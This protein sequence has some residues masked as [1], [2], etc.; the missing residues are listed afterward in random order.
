M[1][2]EWDFGEFVLDLQRHQIR[3]PDCDPEA[4][5]HLEVRFLRY[6]ISANEQTVTTKELLRE[7]WCYS[8]RSNTRAPASAAGRIRRKM[9]RNP[10]KP[11]WL[12]SVY[13]V[14]YRLHLPA[15]SAPPPRRPRPIDELPPHLDGADH[16]AMVE[17]ALAVAP[18]V[19]RSLSTM[20][21]DRRAHAATVLCHLGQA[22][23]D[24]SPP[25]P[26]CR[27]ALDEAPDGLRQALQAG[28]LATLRRN[29][30]LQ[31]AVEEA[32]ECMEEMLQPP[33]LPGHVQLWV[34]YVEL[35]YKGG[36][37]QR[38]EKQGHEALRAALNLNLLREAGEAQ[39]ALAGTY[40]RLGDDDRS[41]QYHLDSI[42]QFRSIGHKRK[43]A[44]AVHDLAITDYDAGR[45]RSARSGVVNSIKLLDAIG[46][47]RDANYARTSMA[48]I[49]LASGDPQGAIDAAHDALGRMNHGELRGEALM[50]QQL[51]RAHLELD[52][53]DEALEHLHRA[54]HLGTSGGIDRIAGHA[55][56]YLGVIALLHGEVRTARM[57]LRS[58]WPLC[59]PADLWASGS[60][61]IWLA[62]TYPEDHA[63][64]RRLTQTAQ[65]R[66][67]SIFDILQGEGPATPGPWSYDARLSGR[68]TRREPR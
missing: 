49:L 4:L 63:I 54:D 10:R 56:R 3:R 36:H 48:A 17:R 59:Q 42:R 5:T 41:R 9:E 32:A 16:K 26:A 61:L 40:H 6:M 43:E 7:V 57:H 15:G 18:E 22:V 55:R 25:I 1:K 52:Q 8:D 34:E 21:P 19:E 45:F 29:G 14:G 51:G 37:Y 33:S 13:G 53:F 35:L 11:R 66:S 68:I 23:P 44:V 38:A 64:S 28:I 20:A 31:H 24:Y 50:H 58:A 27:N 46:A 2:D 65:H 67:G 30:S 47:T 39:A 12:K 60:L 62:R